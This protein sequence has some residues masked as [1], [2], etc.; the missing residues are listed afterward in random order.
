MV[1]L[2]TLKSSPFSLT[3][4]A[5]VDVKIIAYNVYGDSAPSPLASDQHI[6]FVPDPPINL[7]NN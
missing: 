4:G 5:S 2:S 7:Q 6:V 3:L 1:Y